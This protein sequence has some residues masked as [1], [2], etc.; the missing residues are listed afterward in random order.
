MPAKTKV[1]R[2]EFADLAAKGWTNEQLQQHFQVSDSTIS[3]I[4]KTTGT[5]TAP[6]M[7]PERKAT[8]EAMLADEWSFAEIGRTEGADPETLRRH[9]PG[10]AWT[11]AQRAA[12]LSALRNIHDWNGKHHRKEAA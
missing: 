3:R 8:I 6:R 11:V 1:D 5:S 4:R 10:Q 2:A 7:T 12:H 9:F